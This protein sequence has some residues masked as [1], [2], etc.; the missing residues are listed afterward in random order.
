[1]DKISD[2]FLINYLSEE[3]WIEDHSESINRKN[4]CINF[5]NI[6]PN[7]IIGESLNSPKENHV[8]KKIT[9]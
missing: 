1:M 3:G 2:I 8:K 9:L 7:L 4:I 5:M 6:I